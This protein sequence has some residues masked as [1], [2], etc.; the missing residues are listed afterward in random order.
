VSFSHLLILSW[1]FF[2]YVCFICPLSICVSCCCYP[3]PSYLVR[4]L[5][6]PYPLIHMHCF[7]FSSMSYALNWNSGVL[8][9][10]DGIAYWGGEQPACSWDTTTHFRL[11]GKLTS[12]KMWVWDA[13]L[14]LQV[15]SLVCAERSKHYILACNNVG[16][17]LPCLLFTYLMWPCSCSIPI[18]F[19]W[20]FCN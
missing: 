20:I 6:H 1:L 7:L 3:L 15:F 5:S 9:P 2:T 18:A 11:I 17:V 19:T 16:F 10:W 8:T 14:F 12:M 13:F 4:K